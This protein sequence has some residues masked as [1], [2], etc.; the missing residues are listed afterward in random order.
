MQFKV[1]RETENSP[2][3]GWMFGAALVFEF[4]LDLSAVVALAE[5]RHTITLPVLD[6]SKI[7]FILLTMLGRCLEQL[8]ALRASLHGLQRPHRKWRR[9][10]GCLAQN[11]S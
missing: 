3:I 11:F 5:A 6:F 1:T 2:T 7:S 8:S 10:S 9:T 4:I